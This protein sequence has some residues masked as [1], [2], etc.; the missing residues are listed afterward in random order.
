MN[1]FTNEIKEI[2]ESINYNIKYGDIYQLGNHRLMCG[3]ATKAKDVSKLVNDVKI[4]LLLTDPPYNVDYSGATEDQL[5]IS[6]DNLNEEVFFKF[7]LDSFSNAKAVMKEGASFYIWHAETTGLSFRLACQKAGLN[8]RQCLVW[9]K[10]AMI[11]GRQDYQWQHEP[12]LY[13][14]KEGASHNWYGDRKQTTVLRFNKPQRSSLHPTMKPLSLFTY[15]V[16]NSSKK[17]DN[18]LDLFGGSGTTLIVCEQ[19]KRN[20]YMMELDANYANM[21][22]KRWENYTGKKAIKKGENN[23]II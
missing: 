16:L 20:C 6:N 2:D 19:E 11:M 21:I 14:W 1:L 8:I 23:E 17:D 15:Q 5:K 7:L 9:V 12:C 13:G 18:V 4:D 3:D 22:I 10:N